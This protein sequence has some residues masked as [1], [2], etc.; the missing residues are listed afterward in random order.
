MSQGRTA[1]IEE[2]ARGDGWSPLRMHFDVQSFGVNAWTASEAGSRLIS[3]HDEIPSGH[4]ELY[5]ITAGRATFMVDGDEIDAGP[6]TVVFVAD[7]A[8]KRSAIAQ[9]AGTTVFA[10]GGKPGEAYKPRAWETNALVLPLF[11][12]GELAEAKQMLNEALGRYDDREALLYNLACAEARLGEIDP[13][14]EHL[15]TALAGRPDLADLAR[16]DDD[17]APLR[18]DPR[19]AAI[20]PASV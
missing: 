8:V 19:F 15:A 4:E 6:G 1:R 20:V 2:L 11:E 18:E 3:E 17:L 13:A 5:L 12:R 9:D 10:V 7:P 14:L 16:G